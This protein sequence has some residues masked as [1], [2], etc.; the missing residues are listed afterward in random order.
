MSK[1]SDIYRSEYEKLDEIKSYLVTVEDEES[2][3]IE[4]LK[5][6]VISYDDLLGQVRLIT[7]ISDR[8]QKKLNSANDKLEDQ[9]NQLNIMNDQLRQ[10]I[11]DLVE[12]RLSKK[13][14]TIVMIAAVALFLLSEA[15]LEPWID[16]Y[17]FNHFA[18]GAFYIG[19]GIK[20]VIAI[21]IKPLES[22]LE[23]RLISRARRDALDT[24]EM[25]ETPDC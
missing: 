14:T 20:A 16:S 9:N 1:R 24:P 22:L 13:A 25:A 3:S 7:R 17:A 19:L 4:V 21:S 2:K 8:L 15:F 11:N 18:K 12:A 10:T 5:E 6:L 23:R